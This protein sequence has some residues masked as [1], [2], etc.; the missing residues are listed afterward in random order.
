MS[1]NIKALSA[2]FMSSVASR[3]RPERLLRST[4][5]PL[6]LLP[7]SSRT[8]SSYCSCFT[9]TFAVVGA[10]LIA[11]R[12]DHFGSPS[13]TNRREPGDV[14][15]FEEGSQ[16]TCGDLVCATVHSSFVSKAVGLEKVN[17]IVDSAQRHRNDTSTMSVESHYRRFH[18]PLHKFSQDDRVPAIQS[19]S[20][21]GTEELLWQM[22]GTQ[23]GSPPDINSR[24][25]NRLGSIVVAMAGFGILQFLLD[26]PALMFV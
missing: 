5:T 16:K 11:C 23:D 2:P 8:H 4:T 6:L 21:A 1:P 3:W 20:S 17:D 19:E 15:V 25:L 10:L 18:D 14:D 22:H 12:I 26:H 13:E 9:A 24:C 7:T